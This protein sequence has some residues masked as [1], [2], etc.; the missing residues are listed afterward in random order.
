MSGNCYGLILNLKMLPN[1]YLLIGINNQ[2][3][4]PYSL[5]NSETYLSTGNQ[6]YFSISR[7]FTE[8]LPEPYNDCYKDVSKY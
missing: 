7:R 4:I 3:S 1:N 6:Y 8:M 2:S 5:F